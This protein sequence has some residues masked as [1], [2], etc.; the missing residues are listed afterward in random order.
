MRLGHAVVWAC[1][2]AQKAA[3]PGCA[4]SCSR[5]AINDMSM[6]ATPTRCGSDVAVTLG[7]PARLAAEQVRGAN[8]SSV[9]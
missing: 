9:R 8:R 7:V 3:Q 1:T 2:A 5:D 4:W 6:H